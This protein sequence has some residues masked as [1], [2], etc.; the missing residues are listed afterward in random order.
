[1]VVTFGRFLYYKTCIYKHSGKQWILIRWLQQ[2]STD[3][4]LLCFQKGINL[5]SA[6]QGLIAEYICYLHRIQVFMEREK[7]MDL[8]IQIK[9][10]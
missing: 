1:M 2:K 3:L 7:E 9:E 6:G 10:F 5:G 4:D 8:C